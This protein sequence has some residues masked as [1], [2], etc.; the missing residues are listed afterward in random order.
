MKAKLFDYVERDNFVFNLSGLTKIVSFFC[1]TF[2]VMFSYDI[3][4]I[5]A[6]MVFS[7]VVLH[8]S[9]IKFSQIK[10]MLY[11]ALIFLVMN[12]ALTF[13]FNPQYGVEI[14][15]TYHEIFRFTERYVVTQ[16]QLLYQITKLFKYASVIPLG[17]MFLLTT[18]PS[19]FAAS[20][21]SIGVSYK[22]TY[23]LALTLRYFPDMI[24]DYN[25][26]ALA[27]QSRGLDLSKKEKLG[28]RVKN[29]MNICVP[30]IFSTMDRIELISNAMDL[31]GFGKM[32]KRTWYS[33]KPLTKNDY[34]S[35]VF[36]VLVF[37][38]TICVSTFINHGRF[39]NPFI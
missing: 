6:I 35:M 36:C 31:R 4:V 38:G 37:I 34:I 33:R 14:Y 10:L 25:D 20:L 27:Q 30:L 17:M 13:I 28:T 3:R 12:F 9:E 8:V 1:L 7:F 39:W 5:L 11:Y 16:E 18:N 2:A 22:A 29:I 19:E 32:K 26:I 23:A 21:N 15:G 24:R